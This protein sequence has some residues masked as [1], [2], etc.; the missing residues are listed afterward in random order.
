MPN[1]VKFNS[2]YRLVTP[3]VWTI[4][5]TRRPG[6]CCLSLRT[7]CAANNWDPSPPQECILK[8]GRSVLARTSF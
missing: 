5:L 3:D 2:V 6:Y 7:M 4:T 1:L 8:L